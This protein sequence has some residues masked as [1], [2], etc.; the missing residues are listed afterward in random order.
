ME[1]R[2]HL[3]TPHKRVGTFPI[4]TSGL[5]NHCIFWLPSTFSSFPF[6]LFKFSPYPSSSS[7]TFPL[8]YTLIF[9]FY[10][11]YLFPS[12]IPLS[13]ILAD[14]RWKGG[15]P[16]ALWS[17]SSKALWSRTM[18]FPHPSMQR[19]RD[20]HSTPCP[21]GWHQVRIGLLAGL[22]PAVTSASVDVCCLLSLVPLG[23][24]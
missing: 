4:S 19:G 11:L 2:P 22:Y 14:T 8:S 24:A 12:L 1:L 21:Q 15:R 17:C 20:A 16:L 3:K 23:H 10:L 9:F 6:L 7:L 13:F 5:I 18:G